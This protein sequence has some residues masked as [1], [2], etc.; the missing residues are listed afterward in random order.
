MIFEKKEHLL[1]VQSNNFTTEMHIYMV[2]KFLKENIIQKI[3]ILIKI[4]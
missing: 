4:T 3:K 1:H 2:Y